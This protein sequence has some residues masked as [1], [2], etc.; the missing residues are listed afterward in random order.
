MS[1]TE[2]VPHLVATRGVG[3][4]VSWQ[5]WCRLDLTYATNRNAIIDYWPIS[6]LEFRDDHIDDLRKKYAEPE[7]AKK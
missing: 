7:M 5:K 6:N 2:D 4:E 1:M 3:G